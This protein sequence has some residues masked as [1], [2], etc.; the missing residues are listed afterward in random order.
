MPLKSRTVFY[1]SGFDPNG[2]RWYQKLYREEARKQAQVSGMKLDVGRWQDAGAH[3]IS[4]EIGAEENGQKTETRYNFLCWDDIVRSH[5]P[6]AGWTTHT[7][8]FSN[9]YNFLRRGVLAN[10]YRTAWPTFLCGILPTIFFAGA[11]L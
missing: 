8:A 9:P 1:L 5:W 6:P 11:A 2:A 10:V 7:L 3:C 4:W